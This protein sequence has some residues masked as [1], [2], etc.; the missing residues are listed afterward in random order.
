MRC[1]ESMWNNMSE[2]ELKK[3]FDT[4]DISCLYGYSMNEEEAASNY[5]FLK[6]FDDQIES[7]IGKDNTYT[8]DV[9]AERFSIELIKDRNKLTFDVTDREM[10]LTD[11]IDKI[12]RISNS[13]F[14]G[15]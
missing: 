14:E 3:A 5:P 9:D 6:I 15:E 8:W 11:L 10:T 7:V 4:D 2:E 12:E 13:F 1:Q